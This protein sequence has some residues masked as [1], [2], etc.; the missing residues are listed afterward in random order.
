MGQA[1]RDGSAAFL[2]QAYQN[3]W[4]Q[5]LAS[6][7]PGARAGWDACVLT[8]SD[9]RQAAM[10]RRQLE[11][12]IESGLLPVRTRFLVLPDP[13]GQRIGS[14]GATL[15]VMDWLSTSGSQPGESG[16]CPEAGP[17]DLSTAGGLDRLRILVIHSGGDS[18]RL[19]HCSATGKLFARVP[20]VLPDGRASTIF[21]E[22]LISLSGLSAGL[23]PGILVASG[24]VLLI[25]DHLQI[26]FQRSGVIGVAAAAPAE[27]G[28][29]HGVYVSGDGGHR[30]RAYLHKPP[31]EELARWDAVHKDGTVQIDTG[32][33]WFGARTVRK[34]VALTKEEPV[35]ALCGLSAVP[36]ERTVGLNLYGDLL[37]PMAESTSQEGYLSDTSD[38]PATS[39]IQ[40]ARRVIW[41]SLRHSTPFTVERLQPAVFVH[42]GTS[43]E[44]WHMVA[45]DPELARACGWTPRAAAWMSDPAQCSNAS[46]VLIN[47]AVEGPV[48]APSE[49]AVVTDSLLAERFS[50]KGGT[51]VSGVHTTAPLALAQDIVLHQMPVAGG[52]YVTRLY[53][54]HDNPKLAWDDPN[55]SFMNQHWADW[56]AEACVEPDTLWPGL[57]AAER[58]LWNARLYPAAGDREQSL[59]LSLPLQR[60]GS[61]LPNWLVQWRRTPRFSLAESFLQ[62]D[63]ERILSGQTEVQDRVAARRAYEAIQAERPAAEIKPLF[64]SLKGPAGRRCEQIA[65]WLAEADPIL[66]LRGYEALAQ[67]S[68]EA[69]WEDRAFATLADVIERSVNERRPARESHTP[70]AMSCSDTGVSVRVETA[71]R[72]DFGGGWSDTPPHSIE[73]GGTVLNA[74]LTLKGRYPIAAEACWLP[75]RRLILDSRDIDAT[76]EPECLGEVLAYANPADP[77]ALHKAALVMRGIVPAEGDP[78]MPVAELL[79]TWGA[80]LR[81]RTETNI[82]R[83]SGLGTSS[84]IA[85]AALVCLG[86]LLGV[87]LSHAQLYDEVLC[88]EQMMTTG[89]GWQDQVGGLVGGIKLIATAPGLPQVIRVEPVRLSPETEAE[90]SERLV[91]VYTG[92]QRL[93]KNLLQAVMG[94][95]MARDPEMVWMLGEISRL[96]IAMRDALNAGD[97]SGFGAL[98]QEHW[99]INRRMDPGCTNVFIDALFEEMRPHICGGKLAGAGGGGFAI[100]IARKA[101]GRQALARA[102]EAR[103][104]NTPVSIWQSAIPSEAMVVGIQAASE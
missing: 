64:G 13:Q 79:D 4:Q 63:G 71:A 21:D 74:A 81:L 19:P 50:W 43:Y 41:E 11:W 39:A 84:I 82:P 77:F 101:D 3:S 38:G 102:L 1:S 61:A 10:Y 26:S 28:T 59:S 27:M 69:T 31:V 57:P 96:A 2:Q 80:G 86:R 78:E 93:A 36:A 103:Y 30:V 42:F 37:L 29:H 9:E 12:R 83:G 6:L 22:F 72:I 49:S 35:A 15:R 91:V 87:E 45:A 25:Y 48:D 44:Y 8:A 97:V 34:L 7:Q 76:L 5:Y 56:L 14:G 33:V 23:P 16:R 58:T 55:A 95:W 85:G 62:A 51:I 60:P 104:P 53:G 68:E 98:L 100:V 99:A 54:L 66:R 90:I 40:A 88:L 67:A 52:R 89:G 70:V 65:G 73:R 94:R 46:L 92:Q 75:E 18:K 24:D 20:R 17:L 47:A 32:L